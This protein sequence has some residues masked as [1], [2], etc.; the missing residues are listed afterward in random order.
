MARLR[1]APVA[2]SSPPKTQS[3]RQALKEQTNTARSAKAP[4]YED[5]GN[6]DG[7]VKDAKARRGRPK[8]SALQKDELMMTGGLGAVEKDATKAPYSEPPMTTDELAK[9]DAP[10]PP[11]A[12]A[13][14]RPPRMTRKPVHTEAQSRV[15]SGADER[16]VDDT[17][18]KAERRSGNATAGAALPDNLAPSSDALPSKS[19]PRQR[20]TAAAPMPSE[21]SISPSPPPPGKLQSAKDKRSSMTHPGSVLQ[22]HGTPAVESIILALKNFKRRPRQPSMLAM[23]Q[24]RTASARPSAVHAHRPEDPSIYDMEPGDERDEE[25]FAPDAECTP[26]HA[27]KTEQQSSAKGRHK[28]AKPPISAQS[29]DASRGQ[30]RKSNF[31]DA[32][33]NALGALQAKRRRSTAPADDHNVPAPV[34]RGMSVKR[35]SVDR[36]ATPQLPM[37]SDNVQVVGSSSPPSSTPPTEPSSSDLQPS[38][39]DEDVAVPSTEPQ[40]VDAQ[41]VSLQGPE[42]DVEQPAPNGTMAEPA[43]SP[44]PTESLDR[45]RAEEM[46][47]PITQATQPSPAP[48]PKRRKQ[49]AKPM[50]TATLQ[51][52]L[53]KRRQPLKARQRKSEYDMSGS[54]DDALDV[55]HDENELSVK[56]RRRTQPASAKRQTRTGPKTKARQSKAPQHARKSS[57]APARKSAAPAT[58]KKPSKTYGRA[59]TSDKE[60]ELYE[61]ADEEDTTDLPEVSMYEAVQSKELEDV[62][63]KFADVDEWD[64]TFESMSVDEHRSSSQQ[65]R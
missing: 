50:S 37:T 6:T 1:S 36:H 54:E 15:I 57:A 19:A 35:S 14:R 29:E 59:A 13:S 53:P 56:A 58:S 22:S 16:I 44:P 64:M 31:M 39:L 2:P 52:L 48:E 18:K 55:D 32:S 20:P 17:R 42:P 9:S 5:D 38:C 47:E 51:S 11:T 62:K 45:Q 7:L 25:L 34:Q 23:V 21:F 10:P 27:R 65:W 40:D 43:S 28:Q 3:T 61:S 12:K 8:K 4:L 33:S 46:A 60:N 41:Y 24:Q 30:K 63:K 49:K 26:L